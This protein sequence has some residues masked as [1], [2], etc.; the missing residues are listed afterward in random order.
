MPQ[1]AE[2]DIGQVHSMLTLTFAVTTDSSA[3]NMPGNSQDV[4][5]IVSTVFAVSPDAD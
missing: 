2:C 5:H 4:R 1:F 3:S